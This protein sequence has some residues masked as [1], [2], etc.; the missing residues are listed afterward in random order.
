MDTVF[1]HESRRDFGEHVVSEEREQ[2]DP[3]FHLQGLHVEGASLPFGYD[4]V[5]QEELVGGLFECFAD[6]EDARV[7]L[8]PQAEIPV[9]GNIL[10]A[11][12]TVLASGLPPVLS[13]EVCGT[14]PVRAV[15]SAIEVELSFKKIV[16]LLHA[17]LAVQLF[18]S[19]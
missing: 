16:A 8:S 17:V 2:M 9:L 6:L 4:S 15:F 11:S 7:V 10:G 12:Q 1:L 19:V 3:E 14:L 18:E 13:F 5:F